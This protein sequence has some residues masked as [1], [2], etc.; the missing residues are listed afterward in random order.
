MFS[1][2]FN[3]LQSARHLQKSRVTERHKR[4]TK[5]KLKSHQSQKT[6]L[7]AF[8]GAG[9]ATSI[10]ALCPDCAAPSRDFFAM[11][12]LLQVTSKN[13]ACCTRRSAQL[14]PRMH[15]VRALKGERRVF[16]FGLFFRK[17]VKTAVPDDRNLPGAL[18]LTKLVE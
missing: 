17:A 7:R 16:F 10:S 18:V 4:S 6:A 14:L 9:G 2:D 5:R 3:D 11:T 1:S 12:R 15:N 8:F 13:A